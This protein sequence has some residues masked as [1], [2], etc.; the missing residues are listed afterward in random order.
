MT[1][2]SA[3]IRVVKL[4]SETALHVVLGI[5]GIIGGGW[6]VWYQTTHPP[7]IKPILYLGVGI[8]VFSALIIPTILPAAKGAFDLGKQVV[9]FIVQYIPI[10]IGG[11]PG[12]LRKDDPPPSPPDRPIVTDHDN[13]VG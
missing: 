3:I 5:A 12:G 8:A 13:G 7:I 9:V 1:R 10:N 6:L 2:Q 4:A 11:K